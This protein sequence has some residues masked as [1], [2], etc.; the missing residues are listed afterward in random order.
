VSVYSLVD[1]A[2]RH[3]ACLWYERMRFEGPAVQIHPSSP[4]PL[5]LIDRLAV[6]RNPAKRLQAS[7]V[8]GYLSVAEWHEHAPLP[9]PGSLK[10]R[11]VRG[12]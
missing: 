8:Y 4:R 3:E 1:R 12:C 10:S 6:R 7:V 9:I 11:D 2:A 5:A